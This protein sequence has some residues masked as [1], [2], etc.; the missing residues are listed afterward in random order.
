MAIKRTTVTPPPAHPKT[1]RGQ[2]RRE[3][4]K[5]QF[6]LTA[7]EEATLASEIDKNNPEAFLS[8]AEEWARD[9]LT[10]AELPN[11][12]HRKKPADF[13]K[14]GETG[15][16]LPELI[17]DRPHSREWLAARMLRFVRGTRC[18]IERSNARDAVWNAIHLMQA[19]AL[20]DFKLVFERPLDVGFRV[21]GG[22][23]H[24]K[25]RSSRAEHMEWQALSYKLAFQQPEK[26]KAE[27]NR[28]V[29]ERFGKSES[30]VKKALWR[31]NVRTDT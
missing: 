2:T 7:N 22:G 17:E 31:L 16:A 24:G 14:P 27:V 30:A 29:A 20:A 10:A 3:V 5:F 28:T 1:K 18:Q 19:I 4:T 13:L 26:S 8:R 12:C 23:Q 21:I 15:A 9:V 25:K 11:G 6:P